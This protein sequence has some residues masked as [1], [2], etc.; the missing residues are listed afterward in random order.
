MPDLQ[1]SALSN[2]GQGSVDR[3]GRSSVDKSHS[4]RSDLSHGV[5]EGKSLLNT[6]HESYGGGAA[7]G[8]A[9]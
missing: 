8:K 9:S 2:S 1:M 3:R 4:D 7:S 6:L 5:E